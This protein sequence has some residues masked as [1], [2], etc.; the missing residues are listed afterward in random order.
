M[1]RKKTDLPAYKLASESNLVR[2]GVR[3]VLHTAYA[4]R[5]PL[6]SEERGVGCPRVVVGAAAH[7]ASGLCQLAS[8][9]GCEALKG[10][11]SVCRTRDKRHWWLFAKVWLGGMQCLVRVVY[12]RACSNDDEAGR[13]PVSTCDAPLVWRGWSLQLAELS[14]IYLL[15]Y[16]PH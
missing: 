3:G 15:A 6:G 7:M 13:A 5:S 10:F 12:V 2:Q 14:I 11:R 4:I 9:A 1:D 16:C 8:I